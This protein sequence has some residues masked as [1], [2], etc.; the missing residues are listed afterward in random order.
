MTQGQYSSLLQSLLL[1]SKKGLEAIIERARILY[2]N[3]HKIDFIGEFL[4]EEK[5]MYNMW[6]KDRPLKCIYQTPCTDMCDSFDFC[7]DQK[8]LKRRADAEKNKTEVMTRFSISHKIVRPHARLV[9]APL[10]IAVVMALDD[11]DVLQCI[12]KAMTFKGKFKAF[13]LQEWTGIQVTPIS[14]ME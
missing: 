4:Q 5:E 9:S 14:D 6:I 13:C 8:F 7:A 11:D 12:L 3:Q 2:F 1:E 10:T